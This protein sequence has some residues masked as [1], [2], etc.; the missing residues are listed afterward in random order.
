MNTPKR[1]FDFAD[2]KVDPKLVNPAYLQFQPNKFKVSGDGVFYTLQ[3]EGITIG[4]PA[5]FFRLHVCNLQCVWCDS[6]YTWNKNTPELWTE[7]NNWT[8]EEAETHIENVWGC[9]S[10]FLPIRVI[11]T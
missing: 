4:R 7:A 6:W 8:V 5:V 11:V 1:A 3:G 10:K 9:E 2:S